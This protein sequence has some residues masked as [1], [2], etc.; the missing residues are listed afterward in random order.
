M[1][2][3][4][5]KPNV[6]YSFP[7][8]PLPPSLPPSLPA[9]CAEWEVRLVGGSSLLEGRVEVC[10]GGVWG[11]VCDDL[12]D[13]NDAGVVCRSLG[14]LAEGGRL[15]NSI[16]LCSDH[17]IQLLDSFS[18]PGLLYNSIMHLVD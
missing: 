18:S 5:S 11:T 9:V 12:W 14:Y 8:V 1:C 7:P 16:N 17:R 2:I 13:D 4:I 6:H 15:L 10:R 3:I